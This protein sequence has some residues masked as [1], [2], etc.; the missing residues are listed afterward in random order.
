MSSDTKHC[1]DCGQTKPRTDFYRDGSR[2]D[3]LSF[4]C[5]PC[6]RARNNARTAQDPEANRARARRWAID[7]PERKRATDAKWV[8][9]N[10]ERVAEGQARWKRENRDRYRESL[11]DWYHAN[12]DRHKEL[13][14]RWREQNPDEAR[15]TKRRWARANQ[16]AV[17]LIAANRR[18][19]QRSLTTVPFTAAQLAQKWAY[20]GNKCWIC[21][22]PADS[23]DHVKPVAKGG[24]HML[25]NLRPACRP[26]NSSK[27]DKWPFVAAAA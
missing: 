10:R 2:T 1:K 14:R 11:R 16:D 26:C 3:G 18:A 13:S 20:Y 22:G 12:K 8:A 7:N 25:C 23:T 15:E 24:A 5:R 6:T 17:R 4:Y 21:H 27:C 9:E 19:R